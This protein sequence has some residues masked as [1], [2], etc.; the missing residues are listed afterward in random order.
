MA[1]TCNVLLV[2]FRVA[3]NQSSLSFQCVG[4][5]DGG[6]DRRS[7]MWALA[8]LTLAVVETTPVLWAEPESPREPWAGLTLLCRARLATAQFE[9]FKAGAAWQRVDLG[10]PALEHRFPVGA[11]AQGPVRFRCRSGLG[12]GWTSMSDVL[13]VAG[14]G[15]LA[16][17]SLRAR[18]VS[19]VTPERNADL[20]CRAGLPGVTFLLRR[21]GDDAFLETAEAPDALEAAFPVHQAGNYSCSYRT[22][23]EGAP[24]PPSAAVTVEKLAAPPPPTL[25]VDRRLA[26]LAGPGDQPTLQCVAPLPRVHFQ[27]R[28]G[29]EALRVRLSSAHL[30]RVHFHLPEDGAAALSGGRYTCR[31]RLHAESGAWSEHSAPVELLVS[32]GSLP[33][34]QFSAEPATPSPA[35][36]SLVR[37]RCEAPRAGLRFVLQREDRAGRQVQAVLSPEGARADFQLPSVSAADAANYSCSYVDPATPRAGSAPSA[38]LELRLDGLAPAPTLQALWS[39]AVAAGADAVLRCRSPLPGVFF[40]LLRD[41]EVRAHAHRD[42]DGAADLVLPFVGPQH[43][44]AYTCRYGSWDRGPFRSEPSAPVQLQVAGPNL[45]AIFSRS[46]LPPSEV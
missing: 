11:V 42:A 43:A 45:A 41:G 1:L 7:R 28:R 12:Q 13:E 17:P 37:L 34:P 32:D 9:L 27:L 33:A 21:E 25:Q 18:G 22:H 24:S 10:F 29:E 4:R 5:T 26:A 3:A 15:S 2:L 36:G 19:W 44:G 20:L 35:R 40:E 31:Y 46:H 8:L 38:S 14:P 23:A 30:D 16:P 6:G 39:G